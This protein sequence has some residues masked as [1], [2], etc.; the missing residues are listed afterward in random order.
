[1]KVSKHLMKLF[2]ITCNS[3]CNVLITG[4][5]GTGK[6]S[7]ARQIHEQSRRRGKPFVAVNLATLHEGTLESELF[8][9]EKGSFTGAERTR[10]GRLEVAQGGTV[11]LDEVGELTPRLQARLL[12]FLQSRVISP[13]G[14]NREICLD[15]RVIA[16]THKDLGQAVKRKE[17]R[18]DLFHRLRVISIPLKSL[19][20]RYDEFDDLVHSCLLEACSISKKSITSLSPE[21]AER[22]ESYEWPG[23]FR[24][25]R[26]VLE[27][28][29]LAS[30][31]SQLCTDDLPPWL[32]EEG[33]RIQEQIALDS[34]VLGV[35]EIP[36]TLD[37]QKTLE[38]FEKEYLRRALSRNGGR[39]NRTARQIGLNKTT[40]IRRMRAY[41]LQSLIPN[42]EN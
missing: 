8:G 10:V 36:F 14:S 25:L 31:G 30:E 17:F 38:R 18:E 15:V 34:A 41:E 21:V 42:L 26:N 32:L 29:V 7:L 4:E 11:F 13:V 1:M 33:H 19:R 24:E 12:E 6:T 28:A 5:T 23:N 40:L 39:I 27:F 3:D 2:K 37:F 9:H 20:E 16:A 22:F 35:A